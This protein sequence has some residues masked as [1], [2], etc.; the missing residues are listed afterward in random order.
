MSE[1]KPK[2]NIKVCCETCKY[3]STYTIQDRCGF[4]RQDNREIEK[5]FNNIPATVAQ[6]YVSWDIEK[7]IKEQIIKR[8][9]NYWR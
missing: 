9:E 7:L 8:Y 4:C 6:A 2:K 5:E 1:L 3:Y